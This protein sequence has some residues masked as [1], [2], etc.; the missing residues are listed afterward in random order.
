MKAAKYTSAQ[1]R[2]IGYQAMN[3]GSLF[4][5][6]PHAPNMMQTK[7]QTI[8]YLYPTTNTPP[9]TTYHIL[10]I[11]RH[12]IACV[13]VMIIGMQKKMIAMTYPHQTNLAG[14]SYK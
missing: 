8:Y 3:A 2:L 7:T 1:M 13:H 10:I 12:C 14:N 5:S 4:G 11:V 9:L 6:M